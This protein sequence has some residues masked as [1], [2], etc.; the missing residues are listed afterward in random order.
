MS[1]C[2]HEVWKIIVE[3]DITFV[4]LDYFKEKGVASWW[5][6]LKAM[7]YTI[8]ALYEHSASRA[9]IK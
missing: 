7:D 2:L 8:I 5:I 9:L 4:N 6:A 1:Q 3:T